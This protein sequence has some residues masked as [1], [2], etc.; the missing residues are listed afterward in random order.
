MSQEDLSAGFANL[1]Q[2][3]EKD[4]TWINSISESVHWNSGLLNAL[5]NRVNSIEAADKLMTEEI[6]KH[7]GEINQVTEDLKTGLEFVHQKDREH[8]S[9]L[10][11]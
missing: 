4:A 9:T 11:K 3:Q 1:Q 8:E 6:N 5:V 2:R 10:R 7:S